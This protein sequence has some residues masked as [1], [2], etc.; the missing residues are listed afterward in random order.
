MYNENMNINHRKPR[1]FPAVITLMMKNVDILL[2]GVGTWSDFFFYNFVILKR[3]K[4]IF[5]KKNQKNQKCLQIFSKKV[6]I[7]M[8][9]T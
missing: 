7:Q 4:I 3:L 6:P 9:V 1:E 2:R 8:R 5:E